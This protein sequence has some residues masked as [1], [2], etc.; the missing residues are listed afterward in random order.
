M[1]MGEDYLGVPT[2]FRFDDGIERCM[3]KHT[4]KKLRTH[5]FHDFIFSFELYQSSIGLF[6][7]EWFFFHCAFWLYFSFSFLCFS[8]PPSI[9]HILIFHISQSIFVNQ[10]NNMFCFLIQNFLLKSSPIFGKPNLLLFLYSIS[11]RYLS[12]QV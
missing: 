11:L 2:S 7:N 1:V 6:N 10:C 8:K 5:H 3:I 9:R 12:S 4:S